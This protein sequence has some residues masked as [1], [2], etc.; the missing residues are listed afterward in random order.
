M[1]SSDL[2]PKDHLQWF[3]KISQSGGEGTRR[4]EEL[5]AT[6][7]D[8][9]ILWPREVVEVVKLDAI[10]QKLGYTWERSRPNHSP[11]PARLHYFLLDGIDHTP[12]ATWSPGVTGHLGTTQVQITE[13]G[14]TFHMWMVPHLQESQ[15]APLLREMPQRGGDC[16]SKEKMPGS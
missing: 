7:L 2:D 4:E 8:K 10:Q 6:Q 9:W 11:S 13:Q 3:A 12:W 16:Q 15:A 14:Q 1:C 5:L